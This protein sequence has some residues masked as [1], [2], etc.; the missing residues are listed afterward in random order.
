MKRSSYTPAGLPLA[1]TFI[2]LVALVHIV[3]LINSLF[4]TY[5][6]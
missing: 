1:V 4:V 3:G 6:Q 2:A 5:A